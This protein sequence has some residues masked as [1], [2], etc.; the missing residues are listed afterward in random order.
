MNPELQEVKTRLDKLEKTMKEIAVESRKQ[1]GTGNITKNSEK[2]EDAVKTKHGVNIDP[3]KSMD[4]HL[5]GQKIV[6]APVLPKDCA[7]ES[8]TREDS[9]HHNQAREMRVSHVAAKN[10]MV[11][12]TKQFFPLFPLSDIIQGGRH[13]MIDNFVPLDARENPKMEMWNGIELENKSL[14]SSGQLSGC[15]TAHHAVLQTPRSEQIQPHLVPGLL[16]VVVA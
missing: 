13:N 2:G 15:L 16:T 9:K 10:P 4:D 8:T 14:S 3:T 12:A 11:P 1:S 5:G 6:P 7:S